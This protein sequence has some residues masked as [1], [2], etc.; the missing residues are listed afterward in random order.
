MS[1]KDPKSDGKKAARECPDDGRIV[2]WVD[3]AH[4]RART[5]APPV[6]RCDWS[7]DRLTEAVAR[8]EAFAGD[9][10]L[11]ARVV[12]VAQPCFFE[13]GQDLMTQGMMHDD[14][15]Y[16]IVQGMVEIL[17]DGWAVDQRV[18]RQL[19][20]EMEALDL[21]Q[22]R[23]AT[24]HATSDVLALRIRGEDLFRIQRRFPLIWRNIAMDFALRLQRRSEPIGDPSTGRPVV[25]IGSS[26][27]S[28]GL[29][30][31]V[32]QR[33]DQ[34][35]VELAPW[36]DGVFSPG[37]HY[38]ESLSR[39]AARSDFAVFVAIGDDFVES[40]NATFEVP[41]DNI[42]FELGLFMGAIGHDRVYLILGRKQEQMIK[43][44]SDLDGVAPLDLELVDED[45]C[46][47]T[48]EHL[49]EVTDKLKKL[50][51]LHGIRRRYRPPG[52]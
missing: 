2:E 26:T 15:T 27:E 14:A 12:E 19:V 7:R 17:I 9:R 34:D 21:F 29:V 1:K 46:Q 50:F 8:S 40:R 25:F 32:V 51:D 23:H 48:D 22:K 49:N 42:I 18:S 36:D 10:D 20:G 37:K 45:G 43:L 30:G 24:V 31:S 4:E 6:R 44:P 16:L 3:G 11:A 13:A 52:L 39:Q 5:V 47:A 35:A 28:K 38:L 33:L 41:R